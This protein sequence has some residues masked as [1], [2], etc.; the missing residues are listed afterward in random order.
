MA[1]PTPRSSG[2]YGLFQLDGAPVAKS[3]AR[4]LGMIPPKAIPSWLIEG[5][6]PHAA[7][8]I[9][10]YA[11]ASGVTLLVGELTGTDDLTARL[12]LVRNAPTAHIAQ[13][14]LERFGW[15][16]PA[17]LLGEWSLLH[18]S[19]DGRLT[20]MAGPAQ[21]DRMHYAVVGAHVA[22]APDLFRLA[23]IPWIGREVDEAGL[24][25]RWG[26]A[27]VRDGKG[28]RTMLTRV[29][30]LGAGSS[31]VIE[32]NGKVVQSTAAVFV[33]QPRWKGTFADALVESEALLR[34]IMGER[35]AATKLPAILLSGGLDSSLLAWLAAGE[36]SDNQPLF[37][38]T[39][40]APRGSGLVDETSFAAQV[41]DHLGLRCVPLAP[42]LSANFFRPPDKVLAGASG[43]LLTNRHCLTEAFQIEAKARGATMLVNGTYGEMTATMR[44]PKVGLI[45][46]L[47]AFAAQ[48]YHG[49]RANDSSPSGKYP[50]HVRL[51]PH[52]LANLPEPVRAVM[53]QPRPQLQLVPK[54]TGLLGY[55]PGAAK[56]LAQ[57]NEFYPGALRMDFPFRDMRLYRLFAGFPVAML[58][59]GG[60]DRPVVRAMLDGHLPDTIRLRR[61]GMPAEPDRFQRMQRQALD[62]QARIAAFRKAE[63][64]DWIDLDWLD[65]ALLRVAK[66]GA[67]NNS[68]SN[69]VQLTA[70]AAE[71]LCWWRNRF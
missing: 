13:R 22:V 16:T 57:S 63:V 24:L 55:L 20:L 58:L 50:F 10:R 18:R 29:R 37:S 33:P 36:R 68:E 62:A 30:Q 66:Q 9:H 8:A 7:A 41:A 27:S 59:E 6:D 65:Q 31:V 35:L 47:L 64:D 71:F 60:H 53:Q 25:F 39:S 61:Q 4:A 45:Q 44:L 32:A 21:R 2:I 15:D 40:A 28:D 19:N 11:D 5:H 46:R 49:Q 34:Q 48:I 43:P 17:E 14:A 67:A 38:L 1:E 3:D 52:R 54:Q 26:Q 42:A 51:A 69:E 56:S 70:L 23:R 12:D